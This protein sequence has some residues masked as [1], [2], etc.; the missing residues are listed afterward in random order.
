MEDCKQTNDLK[1]IPSDKEYLGYYRMSDK[2]NSDA[3]NGKFNP[4]PKG[5]NPFIIEA[6]LIATD[7]SVSISID[8]IDGKYLVGIVNWK[9]TDESVVLEEQ[10][11]L[12]HRLDNH[13]K[14]TFIRAWLPVADPECADGLEVL[15]PAWRAFVGFD[16][17]PEEIKKLLITVKA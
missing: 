11:Y 1:K 15:Q 9:E 6:N 14:V 10:T 8:H 3:V 5:N 7:G 13:P 4:P 17:I 12:T 2:T 16:T